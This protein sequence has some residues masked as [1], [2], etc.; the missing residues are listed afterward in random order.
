MRMRTVQ[1]LPVALCSRSAIP[2]FSALLPALHG[3]M[4]TTQPSLEDRLLPLAAGW[5]RLFLLRHGETD[6]NAQGKIQG[7][8]FDIALNSNGQAQAVATAQ[9]LR[10]FS[11]AVVAS[12]PLQRASATADLL[13]QALSQSTRPAEL[14]NPSPQMCRVVDPGLGEMCFGELEG[15]VIRGPQS[16]AST[17]ARF[18]QQSAALRR[19]RTLPWPGPGGESIHDVELRATRAIANIWKDHPDA[20]QILIVAHGR[21]NKILLQSLL[22]LSD[23]DYDELSQG[24][25]CVNVLDR[26]PQGVYESRL[27]NY[28][29]HIDSESAK[30]APS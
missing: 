3:T 7:G 22:R 1:S 25:T 20:T 17:K 6:W 16:T 18:A 4:A 28:M 24:N 29:E 5:Q 19:D 10:K 11:F 21:T 15:L 26:S 27:L 23:E 8:G 14:T 30:N 9:L 2:P 12:S 13:Y